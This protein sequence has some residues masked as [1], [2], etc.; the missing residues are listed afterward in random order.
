MAQSLYRSR[1]SVGN[2]LSAWGGSIEK[3]FSKIARSIWRRKNR[4]EN[5]SDD[6]DSSHRKKAD[7]N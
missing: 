7:I 6:N 3:F 2:R 4:N 5:D 1:Q